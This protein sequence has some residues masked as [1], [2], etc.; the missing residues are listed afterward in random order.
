MASQTVRWFR[1]LDVLTDNN[2]TDVLQEAG[3]FHLINS[4]NRGTNVLNLLPTTNEYLIDHISVTY[5][6][7]T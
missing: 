4:P 2:F 6:D 5:D 7:S 3:L 1:F